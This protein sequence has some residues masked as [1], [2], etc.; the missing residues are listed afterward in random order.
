ME[1]WSSRSSPELELARA[2]LVGG[3]SSSSESSSESR[4]R[5]RFRVVDAAVVA[6]VEPWSSRSSLSSSELESVCARLLGGPSESETESESR[7][8][9]RFRVDVAV[10]L[11]R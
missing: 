3:P 9:A 4:R 5:V 7:R 11:F 1:A 8:R 10:D 2:Q 6:Y